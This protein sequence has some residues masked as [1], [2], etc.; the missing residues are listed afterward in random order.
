MTTTQVNILCFGASTGSIDLSVTGGTS[1]YT[2][3]WSNS[4]TTQDVSGL[5]A[6]AYTVTVTDN[7]G[8]TAVKSTTITQLPK[9]V[10]DLGPNVSVCGYENYTISSTVTGGTPAFT[11]AWSNAATTA[12]IT[13][14]TG[15][16]AAT[17]TVTVTDANNCTATDAIT[18]TPDKNYSNGGTIA[19]SQ[20]N[21]GAFDPAPFTSTADPSGGSGNGAS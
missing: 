13:V 8:C 2:Y 9:L 16:S 20:S 11:Y 18:I 5:V 1:P 19:A 12:N 3:S 15:G 10:I 21:C 6:G 7:N 14:A 17:Y 4:A